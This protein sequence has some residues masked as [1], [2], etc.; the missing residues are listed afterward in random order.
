V[1]L[2]LGHGVDALYVVDELLTPIHVLSAVM[3]RVVMT[4]MTWDD[5]GRMINQEKTDQNVVNEVSEEVD[6][7]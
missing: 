7:W 5:H 1:S 2:I 4:P 6:S 3:V